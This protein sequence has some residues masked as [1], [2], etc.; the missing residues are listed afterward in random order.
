MVTRSTDGLSGTV[1]WMV[2]QTRLVKVSDHRYMVEVPLAVQRG[3]SVGREVVLV[4]RVVVLRR[5]LGDPSPMF[6]GGSAKILAM[7]SDVEHSRD[8]WTLMT[9]LCFAIA[10]AM[11][12]ILVGLLDATP[13]AHRDLAVRLAALTMP[14]ALGVGLR[15]SLA[16]THDRSDVL[17]WAPSSWQLSGPSL[18][19]GSCSTTSPRSRSPLE[20]CWRRS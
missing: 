20:S 16:R 1:V 7:P 3:R 18:A 8:I 4:A 6:T 13:G 12:A 5:R 14:N 9:R 2:G 11:V 10:A 19:C 17:W 15:L